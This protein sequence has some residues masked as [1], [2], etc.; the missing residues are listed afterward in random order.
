MTNYEWT[1]S[2]AKIIITNW[3]SNIKFTYKYK[4]K[5]GSHLVYDGPDALGY[6]WLDYI[7][8]ECNHA[9]NCQDQYLQ[10]LFKG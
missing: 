4:I 3:W 2:N 1:L 8:D 6:I 5:K 7:V 9:N 10:F